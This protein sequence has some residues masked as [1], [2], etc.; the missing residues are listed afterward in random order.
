MTFKVEAAVVTNGNGG[1]DIVDINP[2]VD[3]G[4]SF[5]V[6]VRPEGIVLRDEPGLGLV[7]DLYEKNAGITA[8]FPGTLLKGPA[9]DAI[10]AARHKA[11]YKGGY[12]KDRLVI[13]G[14]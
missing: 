3:L 5:C 11:A 12:T 8:N 1:V 7:L 4:D 6:L 2:A 9:H 14:P 10:I 13:I